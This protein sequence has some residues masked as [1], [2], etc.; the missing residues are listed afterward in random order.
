MNYVREKFKVAKIAKELKVSRPS[1]YKFL[2]MTFD[3]AK[4]YIE[5]LLEEKRKL[6][7]YKDWIIAWL[8]EYHHISSAQIHDWL[9]GR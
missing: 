1:V 3:E 7:P 2:E 8:E 9:L 4:A 5:Q 6:D